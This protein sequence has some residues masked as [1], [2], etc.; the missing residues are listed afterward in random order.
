VNTVLSAQLGRLVWLHLDKDA[1]VYASIVDAIKRE[2]LRTGLILTVTGGLAQVRLSMPTKPSDSNADAPGVRTFP[3]PAEAQGSGYFGWTRN[4]YDN[5]TSGILHPAGDPFL[6]CHLAASSGGETHL[7]HLI[8]GC[9]VR[10][11]HEK[12]HFVIILAEA[13]GVDLSFCCSDERTPAYP[14]GLPYYDLA[15]TAGAPA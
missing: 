5:P 1:D 3:G 2:Q 13:V 11:L 15:A 6:H 9:R 7:G 14:N 4:T 12:S 8:E 10:S